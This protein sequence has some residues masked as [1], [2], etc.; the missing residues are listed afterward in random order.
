MD[1][2]VYSSDTETLVTTHDAEKQMLVDYFTEGGRDLAE[3]DREVFENVVEIG[4]RLYTNGDKI[5]IAS[6]GR[7]HQR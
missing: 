2:I 4:N 6:C 5:R 1:L 3:Y 7:A